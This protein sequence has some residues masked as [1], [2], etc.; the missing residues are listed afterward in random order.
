MYQQNINEIGAFCRFCFIGYNDR[1]LIIPGN[2]FKKI[3]LESPFLCFLNFFPVNTNLNSVFQNLDFLL[4]FYNDGV[5]SCQ[6]IEI[7]FNHKHVVFVNDLL[8]KILERV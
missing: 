4:Y 1:V 8:N 5:N 7:Q 6:I 2:R 3:Q